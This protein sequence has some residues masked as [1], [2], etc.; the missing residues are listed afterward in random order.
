MN[1]DILIDYDGKNVKGQFFTPTETKTKPFVSFT[2]LLKNKLYTLLMHDPNAVGGNVNHWIVV[3]IKNGD[4]NSGQ[5]IVT[6]KGPSP[7]PNTGVHH[8][9]FDLYIQKS[10][11]YVSE[12]INH[13]SALDDVYRVLEL[14]NQTP[15]V[16]KYF[17]SQYVKINGGKIISKKRVKK[18]RHVKKNRRRTKKTKKIICLTRQ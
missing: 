16:E 17:T 6:Y 12:K 1:S 18:T 14:T 5:T 9:I 3:N 10:E 7:P 4:I 11:L 8:Y 13:T 2:G 15:V